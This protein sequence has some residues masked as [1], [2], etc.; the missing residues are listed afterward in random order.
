MCCT[1]CVCVCGER[2]RE[3]KTGREGREGTSVQ[4]TVGAF[5]L[6]QCAPV[7]SRHLEMLNPG[8]ALRHESRGYMVKGKPRG[9]GS[10]SAPSFC[11][12]SLLSLHALTGI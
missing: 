4:E 8:S 9:F 2:D 5:H 11:L 1:V 10:F 3:T 12:P 7:S 6:P